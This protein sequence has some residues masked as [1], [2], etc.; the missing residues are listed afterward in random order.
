MMVIMINVSRN[1]GVNYIKLRLTVMMMCCYTVCFYELETHWLFPVCEPG[2]LFG[3]GLFLLLGFRRWTPIGFIHYHNQSLMIR[4][5]PAGWGVFHFQIPALKNWNTGRRKFFAELLWKSCM[6]HSFDM[7]RFQT[8]I[9]NSGNGG[10]FLSIFD[11]RG[12]PS[13][14]RRGNRGAESL[15]NDPIIWDRA[16]L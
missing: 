6:C 5:K 11:H 7:K 3:V 9:S 10:K 2:G 16:W 15:T 14:R 13:P 12:S 1:A 8:A 4:V